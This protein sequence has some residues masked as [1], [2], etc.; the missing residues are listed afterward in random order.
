MR[1]R[2]LSCPF[3]TVKR[4]ASVVI[5]S[6]APVADASDGTNDTVGTTVGVTTCSVP[7]SEGFAVPC[8]QATRLINSASVRICTGGFTNRFFWQPRA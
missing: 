4:A 7:G 1:L 5:V 6:V 8:W 3:S 2:I